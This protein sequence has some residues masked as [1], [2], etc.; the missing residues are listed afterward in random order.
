MLH[1]LGRQVH[2]DVL[3]RLAEIVDSGGLTPV[4]DETAFTMDKVHD[5]YA[6]LESG[7]AMG[8]VVVEV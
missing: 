5:A 8:K 4:L 1:D 6:R 7:Q 2:G 3:R